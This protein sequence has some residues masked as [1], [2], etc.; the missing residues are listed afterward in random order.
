M[1]IIAW[2]GGERPKK[3]TLLSSEHKKLLS[4]LFRKEC[5]IH[6]DYWGDIEYNTAKLLW[7]RAKYDSFS[8]LKASMIKK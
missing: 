6:I 7:N 3:Y 2:T 8:T 1:N 4:T 5:K